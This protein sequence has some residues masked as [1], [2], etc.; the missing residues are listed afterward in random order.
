MVSCYICSKI[1]KVDMKR[2]ITR[3][4]LDEL[5]RS[6]TILPLDEQEYYVGGGSGTKE[7]PYTYEEYLQYW[8]SGTWTGGYVQFS[9]VQSSQDNSGSRNGGTDAFY[10]E[11]GNRLLEDVVV[12]GK[13]KD[14][15]TDE[16]GD[17]IETSGNIPSSDEDENPSGSYLSSENYLTPP[18]NIGG[19]GGGVGGSGS[20]HNLSTVTSWT[21]VENRLAR[22]HIKLC[23]SNDR[24]ADQLLTHALGQLFGSKTF[25]KLLSTYSTAG[26]SVRFFSKEDL[27][28]S[29]GREVYG[30][31]THDADFRIAIHSS[32]IHFSQGGAGVISTI[33]H[34]I[35]H[36]RIFA[37]RHSEL[38]RDLEKNYPGIFDYYQRYGMGKA[39]H[40]M[41]AAH[42][43][44]LIKSILLEASLGLSEED[45][46]ALSWSGLQKTSSWTNLEKTVQDKYLDRINR[47]KQLKKTS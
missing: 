46:E 32:L 37:A 10:V 7:D 9:A 42:F 41:I 1:E 45:C 15:N 3:Q 43:R 44:P 28:D 33:I 14:S 20:T 12:P 25:K 13:R 40:E 30:L 21:Q 17:H 8:H 27:R 35:L 5:Q 24:K 18:M 22:Y 36:A 29:S 2:K 47:Y 19:G 6:L 23:R 16:R 26:V 39:Q 34:E 4:S 38:G 11:R 31:T